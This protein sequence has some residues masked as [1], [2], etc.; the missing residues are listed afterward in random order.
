[1]ALRPGDIAGLAQIRV[2]QNEVSVYV[3][4][5]GRKRV[6]FFSMT[7][8]LLF[9]QSFTEINAQFQI[10]RNLWNTP[11]IISVEHNGQILTTRRR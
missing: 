1:M 10:P 11:F 3:P 2:L 4:Q 7:G 6:L 9:A 8:N 5:Q